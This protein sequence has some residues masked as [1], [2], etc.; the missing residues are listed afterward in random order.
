MRFSHRYLTERQLPDKA[1][2]VLDTACARLALG[3]QAVPPAI[4][5]ATRTLGDL[6]AQRRVLEREAA[7]GA[8]H[9]DRLERIGILQHEIEER[10]D[11]LRKQW[12]AERDLVARIR[13]ARAKIEEGN[14][15]AQP[16]RDE[17]W[18]A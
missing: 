18:P 3:Q 13:E 1:V 9:A 2:S 5:D 7:L 15:D 8:D 10:R 17:S 12:D 11:A 14:G 4:E 6:A 16:Q